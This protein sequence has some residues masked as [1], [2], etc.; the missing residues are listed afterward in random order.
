MSKKSQTTRKRVKKVSKS[1][2]GVFLDTFLA[3]QAGRPR[4]TFLRLFGDSGAQG[5][6]DSC[7]W[8][9]RSATIVKLEHAL[10]ANGTSSVSNMLNMGRLQVP[11][12]WGREL[13]QKF[14]Q[15]GHPPELCVQSLRIGSVKFWE[16]GKGPFCTPTDVR[17]MLAFPNISYDTPSS[18][19]VLGMSHS[20]IHEGGMNS[21]TNANCAIRIAGRRMQGL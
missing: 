17:C 19:K 1:V 12:R 5:C 8:G 10:E 21:P 20:T 7:I 16:L 4:K 3:L 11:K 15:M 9:L 6:G 13:C 14:T 2:S 18:I